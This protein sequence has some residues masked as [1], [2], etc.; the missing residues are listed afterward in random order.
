MTAEV[1]SQVLDSLQSILNEVLEIYQ[2]S[3]VVKVI[4]ISFAAKKL[5]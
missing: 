1:D 4:K 5:I 2:G 3:V